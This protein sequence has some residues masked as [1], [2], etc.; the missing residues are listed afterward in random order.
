MSTAS[1]K[2]RILDAAISL[3]NEMG[4][5]NVRLQHISDRT[6]ISL[7]NITYH[8]RTKDDIL[9]AI[10]QEVQKAQRQL[11]AAFR[12]LPLLEDMDRYLTSSFA[13]QQH[14]TFF[15][16]DTLELVRAYPDIAI[17]HRKHLQWQEQQLAMVFS[18]NEA[19][20]AFCKEIR[21]NYYPQLANNWLWMLE[22]WRYRRLVQ[23]L[24][25][26]DLSAFS[27][28]LWSLLFPHFSL[29]GQQEYQQLQDMKK[30]LF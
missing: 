18:F 12:T 2:R 22:N 21:P 16:L 19:R 7:G 25:V 6:I 11:L 14:Y 28:Q 30:I 10:W 23:D 29:Q 4:L 9:Q 8:Y 26:D 3:F 1:T 17:A 5:V 20:G 15:Y 13:L 27:D 24:P